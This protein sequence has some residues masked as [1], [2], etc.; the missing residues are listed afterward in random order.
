[1]GGLILE[2][3]RA[4]LVVAIAAVVV[5]AV[6]PELCVHLMV[7]EVDLMVVV[8]VAEAVAGAGVVQQGRVALRAVAV[9]V[10]A[11][12]EMLV[13][14]DTP[15]AQHQAQRLLIVVLQQAAYLIQSQLAP[16]VKLL[17][18]GQNNE[19]SRKEKTS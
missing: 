7:I 8:E 5:G 6:V 15:A 17:F 16:E 4:V 1:M 3:H 12:L 10:E 13:T 14:E 2:A 18:H 19:Q 9:G 11:G